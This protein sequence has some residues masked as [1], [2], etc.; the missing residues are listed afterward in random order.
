V[1]DGGRTAGTVRRTPDE[2]P[3]TAKQ[4]KL[5]LTDIESI[6]QKRKMATTVHS[7]RHILSSR[8]FL[9]AQPQLLPQTS[10]P[11]FTKPT[12]LYTTV[13]T[14]PQPTTITEG[15]IKRKTWYWILRGFELRP[16][17]TS[18][19]R[20]P[21]GQGRASPRAFRR[22]RAA[23]RIEAAQ[24]A[25]AETGHVLLRTCLQRPYGCRSSQGAASRR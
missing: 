17:C 23:D 25:A 1:G 15:F 24:H 9:S 16:T 21:D 3:A 20:L 4:Q 12:Y 2:R 7:S 14:N 6:S 18:R 5:M 10:P 13:V 8:P 19:A 11:T 22:A